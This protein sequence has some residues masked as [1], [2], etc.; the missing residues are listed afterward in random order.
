MEYRFK[1]PNCGEEWHRS[2]TPSICPVHMDE[3]NFVDKVYGTPMQADAPAAPPAV[4][5]SA[6]G[7]KESEGKLQWSL[8]PWGSVEEVVKV[9][10]FGAAKYAPDNWQRVQPARKLYFEA[11]MRHLV[12][13]QRGEEKDGESGLPHLAHAACDILFLLWFKEFPP[14]ADSQPPAR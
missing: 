5:A 12:A 13:W 14:A 8:V 9:L 3:C 7:R 2:F 4:A 11:A 10:M 1:C 6:V